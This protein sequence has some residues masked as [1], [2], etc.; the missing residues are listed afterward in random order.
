MKK[1]KKHLLLSLLLISFLT[2]DCNSQQIAK[3]LVFSKTEQFRHK[4]IETGIE[5]IK[6]LGVENHFI[7]HATENADELI[8][9]MYNYNA[10]VFLSTSGNVLTDSQQTKFEQYI[11]KGG[12]YVGIHAA[13][14][15][16]YEWPWY[17][18]MVGAY[19][20]S[21]PK[22]QEATINVIDTNHLA[23][24]FL[25]KEWRLFE[26]WYNYKEFNPAIKVLMKL[27]ENSYE[28]G[29]NGENH[30]IS[31][32]HEYEGGKV[33]YTGLGHREETY[34]NPLFLKHILGGI[35]YAMKTPLKME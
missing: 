33:F 22:Q 26:E 14:D 1:P 30:P 17:G 16:E 11:K 7:V 19:F 9:N 18:K 25:E 24:S 28:G 23:T 34:K 32:Y 2:I 20:V 35:L 3:V 29:E 31:W 6:K 4:S 5:S 13:A 12:G 8:K 27:D 15:T 10:L 21:H